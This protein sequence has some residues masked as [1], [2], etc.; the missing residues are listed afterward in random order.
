EYMKP[1]IYGPDEEAKRACRDVLYTCLDMGLRLLHPMM[2]FVTEELFQRLPRRHANEPPSICV[3]PYPLPKD[4]QLREKDVE[5]NVEFVQS[6]VKSLR[7]M[8]ADYN[9]NKQKAD[10]YLKV[11]DEATAKILISFAD[12]IEASTS[13]NCVHILINEAPPSGCA[14]STVSTKCETNLMLKG[15]IDVKKEISKLEGKK[16]TLGKQLIKLKDS[17]KKSD[18]SS[19]VPEDVRKQN[20]DKMNE[21]ETEIERLVSA[22][23][24]LSTLES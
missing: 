21:L 17:T 18:Y 14:M 10:V 19:K 11:S 24:T 2:P 3:T 5:A 9:L 13:A 12:V 4:I 15:L 1:I 6:V 23:S 22:L 20:T 16:D 8:R 7:S